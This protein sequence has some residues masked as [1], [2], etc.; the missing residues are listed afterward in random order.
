MSTE[1]IVSAV[2]WTTVATVI[3]QGSAIALMALLG[4][5]P[6]AL[7]HELVEVQNPAVGAAFFVVALTAALFVSPMA[8]SGFTPDPDLWESAA[9]VVGGLVM[10][11]VYTLVAFMLAHRVLGRRRGEGLLGFVRRE[12]VA[13]QNVSLTLFFGGLAVI[14]FVAVVYQL[15]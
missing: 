12:L 15:I 8:S 10:A 14:P 5:R 3:S 7:P 6:R 2:V 1:L 4:V 13:E 11:V 9:W